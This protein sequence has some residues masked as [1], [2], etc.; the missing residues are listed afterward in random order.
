MDIRLFQRSRVAVLGASLLMISSA[1]SS[2]APGSALIDPGSGAASSS[3]GSSSGA[4]TGTSGGSINGLGG[5]LNLGGDLGVG[6]GVGG[7]P[8]NGV[9]E[10]CDGVDNNE[11]GIIDD[12]DVGMD[13]VCDCLS[14]AT[15]GTIGPWSDGG[16]IFVDWLNQRSPQGATALGDQVLTPEL[17]APFQ[18]IVTL[19]VSTVEVSRGM[20]MV[21]ANHAY[22]P[23]EAA[24]FQGWVESGG[25][26]MTTIG[27]TSDESNEVANVNL[28]LGT[29]GMG[30]STT[31]LD[32]SGFI[33]NWTAHPVTMG[34]S[35]INTDNGVEPAG[36]GTTLAL[37][38]DGGIALQVT[39]ASAGRAVVWGDEWIT[40]DSEWQDVQDQQVELFWLNILKWLSP[41]DTC[42]VA[43]PPIV[44]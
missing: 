6:G 1:C 44:Q 26:A 10:V 13:G 15:L 33:Q 3:G 34:V 38:Q 11:N 18:I 36:G 25:G 19:H 2:T 28:L 27:Y 16:N 43:I 24:A 39:Q 42:Q 41:P 37:T 35:N 32:L 14:I 9:P 29:V 7:N 22:S 40:Y 8:G 23:E 4:G 31:A 17:L 21:P 30:Y 5:S 12:V 20:V